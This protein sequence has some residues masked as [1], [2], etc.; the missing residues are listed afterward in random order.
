[1]VSR[2]VIGDHYFVILKITVKILK[3]KKQ[4]HPKWFDAS[5]VPGLR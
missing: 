5:N 2:Y 4:S 3:Y 1:M